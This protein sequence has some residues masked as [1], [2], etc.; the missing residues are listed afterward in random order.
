[1]LQEDIGLDASTQEQ[2]INEF[3]QTFDANGDGKVSL[4]E[5]LAFFGDLFESV[6]S[7]GL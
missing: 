4:S 3:I 2:K 7:Q 5:Y 1:M 6:I